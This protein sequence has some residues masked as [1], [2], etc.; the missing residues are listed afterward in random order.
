MKFNDAQNNMNI[1]Y[2]GGGTGILVS[3]LVWCISGL[4][5]LLFTNQISM[6]TLF[7]GGMLIYPVSIA[8]SKILQGSGS[9]YAESSRGKFALE[10][11]IVS[12]VGLFLAFYVAKLQV[13]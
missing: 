9:H 3:G 5:A 6:L 7:F 8:L 12:S 4:V 11:T 13:E 1:S 10:S 2:F